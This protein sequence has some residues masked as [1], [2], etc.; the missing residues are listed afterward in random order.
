MTRQQD[1]PPSVG[2]GSKWTT[3]AATSSETSPRLH[4]AATATAAASASAA[5][6]STSSAA[7]PPPLP[8]SGL[9]PRPAGL[10]QRVEA[11]AQT[12]HIDSNRLSELPVT[13]LS[14]TRQRPAGA[15]TPASPGAGGGAPLTPSMRISA[16]NLVSDLLRKVG[17]LETKLASCRSYSREAR[18]GSL[19]QAAVNGSLLAGNL[20][21]PT[22]AAAAPGSTSVASVVAR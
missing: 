17:A 22:A 21:S 10:P 14:L 8:P 18:S 11:H 5:A 19:R 12:D 6:G 16:L 1:E 13:P 3:T 20:S 7:S 4:D 15:G 2:G 9:S